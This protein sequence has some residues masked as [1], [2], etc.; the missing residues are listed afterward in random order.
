MQRIGCDVD[1]KPWG[2]ISSQTYV[3][4]CL[5]ERKPVIGVAVGFGGFRAEI[6]DLPPVLYG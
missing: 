1:M 6:G 5:T 4:D 3:K 2:L